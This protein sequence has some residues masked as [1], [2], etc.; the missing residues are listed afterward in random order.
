M[1]VIAKRTWGVRDILKSY[2]S[3]GRKAGKPKGSH[4]VDLA[5]LKKAILLC[6]ACLKGFSPKRHNYFAYRPN[7]YARGN[8]D[9]CRNFSNR[10]LTFLHESLRSRGI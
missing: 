10:I 2:E 4:V 7:Q 1:I 9:V 3:K 5:D 6:D 8:C